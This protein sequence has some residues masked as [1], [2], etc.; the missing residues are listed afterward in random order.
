M[1]RALVFVLAATIAAT[2]HAEILLVDLSIFGM[3]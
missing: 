3:D 2:A 1:K